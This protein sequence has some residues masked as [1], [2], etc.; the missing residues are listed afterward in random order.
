ML[1]M[2][3][4]VWYHKFIIFCHAVSKYRKA[5]KN[6]AGV[7]G[8]VMNQGGLTAQEKHARALKCGVLYPCLGSCSQDFSKSCPLGWSEDINHDCLAPVAYSGKCVTRKSFT[9]MGAVDKSTWAKVCD[10]T[11]PCRK[12]RQDVTEIARLS[13]RGIFNSDCIPDYSVGCPERFTE[14]D[15]LCVASPAFS[16]PCAGAVDSSKYSQQEKAAYAENCLA[17][18]PCVGDFASSSFARR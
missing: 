6:Y 7:C 5:P 4:R 11:W 8:A 14:K 13:V 12:T 2:A 1:A 10:V 18:W 15:G 9:E 3:M 16:G 17:P